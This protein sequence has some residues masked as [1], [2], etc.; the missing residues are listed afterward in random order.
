VPGGG[1]YWTAGLTLTAGIS[2]SV[3]FWY[4]PTLSVSYSGYLWELDPV[5]VAA[6]SRPSILTA[7]PLG[8]PEQSV[9]CKQASPSPRCRLT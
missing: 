2:E 6:R 1:G 3:S 9:F 8:A 4:S 7:H 5:E